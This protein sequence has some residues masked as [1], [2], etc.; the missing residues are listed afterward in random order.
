[1]EYICGLQFKLQMMGIR[2]N[3]P[4]F[5]YDDN[6]FVLVNITGPHFVLKKKSNRIAFHFIR[7]GTARDEWRTAYIES[8]RN[9]SDLLTKCLSSGEK[10]RK[11]G[12]RIIYNLYT[13]LVA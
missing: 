13:A 1:M 10:R 7:E 5:V 4:V 6:Q 12:S 2:I 3:G 11:F 9:T 8:N